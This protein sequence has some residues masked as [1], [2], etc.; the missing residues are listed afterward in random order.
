MTD[1]VELPAFIQEAVTCKRT[2]HIHVYRER[3]GIWRC[4]TCG[5]PF[6]AIKPHVRGTG[7]AGERHHA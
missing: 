4:S 2:E 7:S 3:D 5:A 6:G 1:P